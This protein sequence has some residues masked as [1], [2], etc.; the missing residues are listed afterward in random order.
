[1]ADFVIAHHDKQELQVIRAK[2]EYFLEQT[3]CLKTNNKTQIFPVALKNGRG[4]DF[5][6]YHIWPTHRRLR[7]ASIGRIAKT[8]KRLQK[9]YS[10]GKIGLVE[11]RQSLISWIAHSSHCQAYGLR[12]KLLNAFTFTRK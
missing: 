5:L 1:M 7:K 8:L 4:L 6:G 12:E 11:I 9:E 2:I 10:D 3:L